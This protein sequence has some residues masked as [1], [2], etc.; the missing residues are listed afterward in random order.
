MKL[1]LEQETIL[2]TVPDLTRQ[3]SSTLIE[4]RA[5]SGKTFI[6]TEL[7]PLL[8]GGGQ[9]LAFNRAIADEL[10]AKLPEKCPAATFH[11]LGFSLLRERLRVKSDPRKLYKLA[12]EKLKTQ[13]P[14]PYQDL[15]SAMKINGL[16]L[17]GMPPLDEKTLSVLIDLRN[18][19]LPNGVS[20]EQFIKDSIRLFK[21]SLTQVDVI[22]FDDMLYLPLFLADKYKWKFDQFPFLM[23]D[24]AQ[25]VSPL[26]LEMVK[27]LTGTVIAVDRKSVV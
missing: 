18:I 11:S 7:A 10:R 4:A 24:E 20:E 15:V 6:L 13:F 9:C 3:R 19:E 22:D 16:G 8:P 17:S 25:D 2:S 5:G 27:R 1:T 12:K 23:I 14:R 21:R 26:R